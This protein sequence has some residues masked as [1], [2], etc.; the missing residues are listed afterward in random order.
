M[1]VELLFYFMLGLRLKRLGVW[2]NAKGDIPRCALGVLGAPSL[3][4]FIL[5]QIFYFVFDEFKLYLR[6]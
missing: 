4:A 2:G 1:R 5:E 6:L 3:L